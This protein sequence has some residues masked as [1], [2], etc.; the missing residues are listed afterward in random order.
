MHV[1]LV[2]VRVR[3]ESIAAFIAAT[4]LNHQASV[5]E[6]GNR[7]FDV[8]QAPD[9]P[10]RFILYEAYASAADAAAHKQTTHYLAWRDTVAGMM[11]EARRGEP[12]NGLF[13]E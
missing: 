5:G 11:A 1:T 3:P 4:R 7:R 6:P 2:H 12:M 13:P 9:D 8:L 10:A